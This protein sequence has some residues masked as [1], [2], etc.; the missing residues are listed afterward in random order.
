LEEGE[1]RRPRRFAEPVEAA[2]SADLVAMLV[3][4]M[5]QKGVY[6]SVEKSLKKGRRCCSLTASTCISSRSSRGKDLDVVLM[7]QGP[8]R[9]RARQYPAG[10]R[11]PCLIALPRMQ[12]ARPT[13][14]A[15][16]YAHGIGGTRGGVLDTTF[17]E[18]TETDLFGEQSCVCGGGN[19]AR[20][21]GL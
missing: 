17:S 10:P 11:V 3:P 18:E 6:E 12:P 9:S 1:E 15:L 7:P 13:R 19:R 5:A 2:A 21:E 8:R 16:S 14:K 4:D 20:C